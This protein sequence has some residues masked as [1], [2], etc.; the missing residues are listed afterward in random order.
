MSHKVLLIAFYE[1]KK[2]MD[3]LPTN[4]TMTFMALIDRLRKESICQR[5]SSHGKQ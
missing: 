1:N 4:Q 2:S 3:Q 5:R